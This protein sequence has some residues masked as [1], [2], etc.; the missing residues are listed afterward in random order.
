MSL[1][2]SVPPCL[3]I[4]IIND[5]R[6]TISALS[7]WFQQHG[8]VP[9]AAAL[10]DVRRH[11]DHKPV[12]FIQALAADV[13]ILDLGIPYAV[14][15]YYAELIRMALPEQPVVLTTGN[16]ATLDGI[17]GESGAFELTGTNE[18]LTSLLALVYKAAGRT[19]DG[20]LPGPND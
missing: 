19:P 3:R 1:L 5:G 2:R 6:D 11:T 16:R 4:G 12:K 18:N 9:I 15:W 7:E 10:T 14:N 8:H 17:V 13:I 20:S